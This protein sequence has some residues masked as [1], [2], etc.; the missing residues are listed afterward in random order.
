MHELWFQ[1]IA[2]F[3]ALLPIANPIGAVPVF[4]A[5]TEVDSRS[6]RLHQARHTA[7]NVILVLATFLVAGRLILDFFHLSLGV[8]RIAGGLLIAR[9]AWEK[10]TAPAHPRHRK[11]LC[12]REDISFT[13][14]AVPLISGPGA[15]GVV[16]GMASKATGW[17]DYLG[18]LLG[19]GF[20]GI[21]LYLCLTLGDSLM[22]HLGKSTID[23]FNRI[24]GFLVLAIA[25]Q[26][27][28]DGT[29]MLLQEAMHKL[30]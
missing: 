21:S 1:A 10:A 25:V 2:T 9:V 23:A 7:I 28:T 29:V 26:F 6:Y 5:L 27:V 24:L 19:I 16:M 8:L 12:D 18:C 15:I 11:P 13:P 17:L 3:L 20:L 22:D 4:H 14:M 30:S